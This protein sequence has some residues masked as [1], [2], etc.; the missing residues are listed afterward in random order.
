MAVKKY[1][2]DIDLDGN[3]LISSVIENRTAAPVSAV[4][5]QVYYNTVDKKIYYYNSTIAQWVEVGGSLPSN[6]ITGT[7]IAGQVSYWSGTATQAGSNDFLWDNSLSI[8]TVKGFKTFQSPAS[9]ETLQYGPELVI[10]TDWSYTGAEWSGDFSTGFKHATGNTGLL[11][12]N[13]IVAEIGSTYLISYTIT[14]RTAGF[15]Q[16]TFGGA[17]SSLGLHVSSSVV[18]TATTAT[19]FS[20]IP[21]STYNGRVSV[22]T[23]KKVTAGSTASISLLTSDGVVRSEIRYNNTNLSIG[24]DAGLYNIGSSSFSIGVNNIS[25]GN[26][27]QKNNVS[28][29]NNTIVGVGSFIASTSG[30]SNTVFGANSLTTVSGANFNT[31]FGS[32]IMTAAGQTGANNNAFGDSSLQRLTAGTQNVAMGDSAM[33]FLTTGSSNVGVGRAAGFY[34][35]IGSQNTF[36]GGNAGFI[37]YAQTDNGVYIGYSALPSGNLMTNEIAIGH[38]TTGSGSNSVTLG[39]ASIVKTVLRGQIGI[40]VVTPVASAKVQIDSTTQGLLP[41]RMTAAQRTAISSPAVGLV[42]YQTDATE[43]LYQYKTGGW[44]IVAGGG[45]GSGSGSVTS[46]SV[47]SA[48]GFAGTVANASTTPAITLSTSVTGLLLGNGTSVSAATPNTD[49]LAVD[50]PVYTGILSTGTLTFNAANPL[51]S[52]QSS[53]NDFNQLLIQNSG[54]GVLSSSDI[55]V[56]NNLSTD[57]DYYGDFGIN[58]SN[59]S[60]TGSLALPNAVYVY[61][62]GGDLVL[63]TSGTNPIH[64]VTDGSDTDSITVGTNGQITLPFY[65]ATTSFTGTS[66]GVL[67]FTSSGNVITLSETSSNTANTLVKRDATGNFSAGKI[68]ATSVQADYVEYVPKTNLQR[69]PYQK[70]RL[71]Y[72]SEASSLIMYSDNPDVE[73][74][75]GERVWIRCRNTT[76]API[77]KGSPVYIAAGVHIPG[78]PVH[79]HHMDVAMADAS[80]FNKIDVV[81]ITAETIADGAHGYVISK[82][83]LT[84]VDTSALMVGERF[85]LGFQQPGSVVSTAPEYPNFPVDLGICL[86]GSDISPR[87]I[88]N[89]TLTNPVVV[90]TSAAHEFEDFLQVS[91]AGITGTTQLNGNTYYIDTINSTQFQLYS[92]V[93]LSIPVD[94]TAF[95]AYVTGGT[96]TPTSHY[97]A[98]YVDLQ[99]HSIEKLRVTGS[100]YIDGNLTVGGDLT[101]IGSSSNISVSSLNVADNW[102]YVGAG[103]TVTASFTGSGLNDMTFKGHYTGTIN[104]TYYVKISSTGATDTFSWSYDN[105]ATTEGSNIPITGAEQTLAFGIKVKFEAL[106]GHT[107]NDK[108]TGTGTIKNVDFGFYGNYSTPNYTHAGFFRDATDGEF[109]FFSSYTPEITG[110]IDTA[111]PSFTLGTLRANTFIGNLNGN[112]SSVTDGVYT[113]LSYSNPAWITSLDWSKITNVPGLSY[114]VASVTGTHTETATSGTKI[115]KAN[116]TSGTF[117]ITLPTAV[118]N[119]ATIIIKKIAGSPDLI[120]DGAGTETIDGGLTAILRRV[121]ESI[122]L[123]SDNSNWFI[124]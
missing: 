87:S 28:G 100:S 21:Q 114:T 74:L 6:L 34:N 29:S 81:G 115:L 106:T 30:S 78:N 121:N 17:T 95:T 53:V 63:A 83:Y 98:V 38:T 2:H 50:G 113:N 65:Q 16:I 4:D 19:G 123:I 9:V 97:G 44:E 84:G 25:I 88:T 70:G 72:N 5:G 49:F 90:T 94:G 96:V 105:F 3:Q 51:V 12:N 67:G 68:T 43:G 77:P 35:T 26:N 92:D 109:K 10:S 103:D 93:N 73:L 101:I 24:K 56:N 79:G 107:L 102:V 124:I 47:V 42:V 33:L 45:G 7:G 39:N 40:G 60:G 41:P 14:E 62:S 116:T 23:I 20:I 27:A 66:A 80:D 57:S 117:T 55:V 48:N 37:N 11:I 36:I 15:A 122:T 91:F 76:G 32:N 46:V 118:G 1:Y 110:N 89:I 112:A 108:W 52:L 13:S 58:G 120:V 8:L 22:T 69:P 82:G 59:Y 64:I 119:T 85:H 31:A 71:Y 104:R 54:A 99:N 75:I 18:L 86:T 61:S 111:D